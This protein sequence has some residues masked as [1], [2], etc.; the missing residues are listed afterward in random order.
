MTKLKGVF[1]A[2][3]TPF[4]NGEVQLDTYRSLCERQ[5]HSGVSGLVPCGTTGET[6]TL[7]HQEWTGLVKT[8]VSVAN[9][10]APV[11]AGC[12]SNSTQKTIESIQQAKELGA[13]AALVVFPY[14]NKP[15]PTGL[16]AHVQAACAQDLPIVL[17]HVPGRTG[18]R[19]GAAQLETLCRVPGVIALKEATGDVTLGQELVNRLSDTNVSLLSGDDFTFA[20]LT[21]M[22]FDGVISVIS[23]PAPAMT[24]AWY[25]AANNGDIPTLREL[26]SKLLPVISALFSSTNPVPC[27][28]MMAGMNLIPN[29]LRLPLC[30]EEIPAENL[31]KDLR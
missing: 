13:D 8:A 25:H 4:H 15:N 12:G 3:V 1:T 2:L 10:N 6:P 7:T 23:N 5:L 30:A 26:R 11:I 27:K 31:W 9:G 18:Q 29:E 24:N 21:A 14:Y 19:L 20:A 17:Y 28:G 22:G 16:F